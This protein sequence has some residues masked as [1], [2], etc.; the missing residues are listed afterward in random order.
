MV[1]KLK[2]TGKIDRRQ[3][4]KFGAAAVGGTM[5]SSR[6]G[7]AFE[8]LAKPQ[9]SSS[10]QEGSMEA[11][12]GGNKYYLPNL[13]T[14][15]MVN[16]RD[17]GRWI[18][19]GIKEKGYEGNPKQSEVGELG[20]YWYLRRYVQENGGDVSKS[21]VDLSNLFINRFPSVLG[22]EKKFQGAIT[23]KQYG[24][25]PE[26]Y[27]PGNTFFMQ[28]RLQTLHFMVGKQMLISQKAIDGLTTKDSLPILL[29][30]MIRVIRG[31][32][33]TLINPNEFNNTYLPMNFDDAYYLGFS[34]NLPQ[35]LG[36]V[37]F[38]TFNG[39]VEIA[40]AN[41]IL[42]GGSLNSTFKDDAKMPTDIRFA[43]KMFE[44]DKLKLG[45]VMDFYLRSDLPGLIDRIQSKRHKMRMMSADEMPENLKVGVF[46]QLDTLTSMTL[47]GVIPLEEA[48]HEWRTMMGVDTYGTP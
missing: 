24:V 13:K 40:L 35:E 33:S 10:V 29:G 22:G 11:A 46:M 48:V 39:N 8:A 15:R 17:G 16:A 20:G 31:V 30:S 14:C 34:V 4:L 7:R 2:G 5:L 38:T 1:D 3:F 18:D 12:F 27:F 32:G 6:W 37:A 28:D 42:G 45:E 43:L 19:R 26:D 23:D 47:R 44:T 25:S 21:L 36:G 41:A 9:S